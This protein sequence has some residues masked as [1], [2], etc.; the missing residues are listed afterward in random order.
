MFG[1]TPHRTW[2]RQLWSIAGSLTVLLAVWMSGPSLGQD[3]PAETMPQ[4]TVATSSSPA[5]APSRSAIVYDADSELLIAIG[6]DDLEDALHSNRLIPPWNLRAGGQSIASHDLD[7]IER[8][9][10]VGPS[11]T[12]IP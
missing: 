7:D 3:S 12:E 9:L 5:V 10:M 6:Q 4:E 1:P 8:E 2:K 11:D